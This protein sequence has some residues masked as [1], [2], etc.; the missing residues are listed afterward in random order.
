MARNHNMDSS[1]KTLVILVATLFIPPI[2]VLL[3][4][5]MLADVLLVILL[6]TILYFLMSVIFEKV[7][8]PSSSFHDYLEKD[9][10]DASAKLK[11]GFVTLFIVLCFTTVVLVIFSLVSPLKIDSIRFQFCP[12][13]SWILST[14]FYILFVFAFLFL[15]PAGELVFYITFQATRWTNS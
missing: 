9:A 15:M 7:I 1:P 13:S 4:T 10:F 5:Y 12:T 8:T 6:M 14:I 11:Q 2:A 3:L